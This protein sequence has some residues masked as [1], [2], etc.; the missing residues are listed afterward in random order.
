MRYNKRLNKFDK[1]RPTSTIHSLLRYCIIMP[2]N[3]CGCSR[4]TDAAAADDDVLGVVEQDS[5]PREVREWLTM[6]FTRTS[7]QTKRRRGEDRLK[8]RSVANAIR[9]GIM[10]DKLVDQFMIIVNANPSVRL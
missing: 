4:R 10:V 5:V 7:A 2:Y 3:K 8:F 1:I 9:A 6:T